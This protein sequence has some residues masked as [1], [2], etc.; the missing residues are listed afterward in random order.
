MDHRTLLLFVA[1][2]MFLQM[3]VVANAAE[4]CVLVELFT[5]TS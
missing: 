3:A 5:T 1:A 2:L 4:R